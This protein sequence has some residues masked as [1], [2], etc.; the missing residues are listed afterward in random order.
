MKTKTKRHIAAWMLLAVFVPMLF[1]SSVHVHELSNSLVDECSEC[2]QHHCHGH[3]GQQTTLIYDCV[4]CQFLSLPMLAVAVATLII[5]NKISKI[6][7]AQLQSPVHFD[8][9][10]IPTLRAP[11]A[12]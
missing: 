6:H 8:A 11:P 3:L 7:F 9:C 4:F 5:Y 2:V 12:V 10:G 1:L